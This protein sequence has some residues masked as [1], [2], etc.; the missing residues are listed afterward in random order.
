MEIRG[1]KKREFETKLRKHIGIIYSLFDSRAGREV[2]EKVMQNL[3][4]IKEE[5]N[6]AHR[7]FDALLEEQSA[8]GGAYRDFDLCDREYA[9]C[10][11][12]LSERLC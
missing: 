12:R 9:K 6:V 11:I 3:D 2:L 5:L 1:K 7:A 8:N 4:L 10:L